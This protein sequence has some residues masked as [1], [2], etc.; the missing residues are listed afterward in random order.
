MSKD[1][2]TTWVMNDGSYNTSTGIWSLNLNA[3]STYLLAIYGQITNPTKI[4]NTVTEV[5]Q[6]V[7]NP[8]GPDNTIPKCLIVFDDGN[9]AQYSIAF[10]YMQSKGIVGTDYVNGYNIGQSGIETIAD[11]QEMNLTGWI[12]ANHSFDHVIL[13]NLTDEDIYNEIAEQTNFLISNG[14]SNGAYDLAYPGGYSDEDVYAIMNELGI[15][16]GR[17]TVGQS[18]GNLNALDLY[19]IPA[20]TL[21]NTTSVTNVEGYVNDAMTSDSTIV[22]LFHNIVNSNA[23]EYQ[24][25]TSDFQS[26]IDYISNI[27]ID[28]IT[29]NDLYQDAAIAPINIP[30]NGSVFNNLSTSNGYASATATIRPEAD[31]QINSTVSNNTPNYHDNIT[32]TITVKNNG[33]N[34]AENVT[35]GEWLGSGYLTYVSDDSNGSYDPKTGIWTVGTLKNG[36]SATLNLITNVSIANIIIT[37]T[38][39]YNSGSTYDPNPVNNYQEINITV[40][41]E[42][43]TITLN[44]VTGLKNNNINL[45]AI[46]NDPHS[47]TP[48][49]GKSIQFSVDGKVI[50]TATTDSNGIA[51]LSYNIIQNIG[52]YT[53]F[54]NFTNDSTY[55]GSNNTSSLTVLPVSADVVVNNTASNYTPNYGDNITFTVT[56]KNNGPSTAQNV[57][58]KEQLSNNNL[59]YIS[60]DSG[61]K[62]NLNTG[63]W[64]I[65]NLISG[66]SATLHIVARV[67]TPNSTITN[68]ATYNP[69]TTDPN[70]NNNNQTVTIIVSPEPASITVNPITGF[71]NNNVNLSATLIDPNSNT[72]LSGKPVQFTVDGINIGTSTTDSNGIAILPYIITQDNGTYLIIAQFMGDST[73]AS[74]NNSSNLQINQ[75]P[76]A[77]PV[78]GLYNSSKTIT[79]NFGNNENVYY[80]LNGSTPTTSSAKYN[81][82][83]IITS[84]TILNFFAED[85]AGNLSP[86]YSQTYT[87]DEILPTV[88]V[89]IKG[90]LYNSNQIITLIMSEAGKI[91]Y[92]LNGTTPTSLSTL[93]TKPFTISSTSTLKYIAIDS[94]NN[95]SPV[96]IQNYVIDKTVPTVVKTNPTN[97]A[98]NVPLTTPM[99]LTFSETILKG[100]N[101]N[102]IYVKN[103]N[104]GKLVQITKTLSS[105]TL[106]IKM[107]KSR[108]HNSTYIIYIPKGAFKDQAGNLIAAYTIK[109][110]TL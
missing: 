51:T 93:Y 22:I 80:T 86:V 55:T 89:N 103:V 12:I 25:L 24:Y 34:N 106:T 81:S 7:Y 77:N 17:T 43:T 30:S 57:T 71:K 6:D 37:N 59:T 32:L 87:I 62:L 5:S 75:I 23:T 61:G 76:T 8:Y 40:P 92:T 100:I 82:P 66:G 67:I 26:I 68:T 64:T 13:S 31:L 11:L 54:A 98:I 3:N 83:I 79:L 29:M 36:S 63:I 19:Q 90:G 78:S 45:T 16:T 52:T 41:F 99:T 88:S 105:N 74:T 101:Y 50:G 47:N 102:N 58:I 110:K 1:N 48:I 109:F 35:V 49:S 38:A 96:Y 60:D 18:I 9:I 107:T 27:G 85:L 69:V 4:N 108:L 91:Y 44:P 21:L 84:T 56:V 73:F 39:T 72:P 104:T 70:L 10:K 65:G 15:L 2:G 46:L 95:K 20:Y 97:N 28:C 53:I 94:A 42:P 14:L 33:P